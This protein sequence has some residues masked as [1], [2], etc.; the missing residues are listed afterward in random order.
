MANK[1]IHYRHYHN[2]FA[3]QVTHKLDFKVMILFNVKCLK[4][5]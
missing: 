2:E 1:D 4:N 3:E 5:G